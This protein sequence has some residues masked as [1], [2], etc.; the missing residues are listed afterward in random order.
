MNLIE[1]SIDRLKQGQM[2]IIVDDEQRENEGDLVVAAEHITT[3]QMAFMIRHTGGVVCVSLSNAIADKLELPH[4]VHKNT[5]QRTTSFTVS[6]DAAQSITTGISAP[7]RVA[8]I[9]TILNV[10][11]KPN[12]LARPGHVFPLRAEAGGVL[13][14]GGHT[15]ASVDLCRIAGLREAAVISEL[16]N[17]DGT[18]MRGAELLSFAETNQLMI[19]SVADIIAYRHQNETFIELAAKSDLKTETGEWS[20]RVYH[21]TLKNTEHVALV[22]GE[23][24]KDEPVLVR[25]HSECLTG[26]LFGSRHCDC[27]A[28][29]HKAMSLIEKEGRGVL[30]YM[31]QEGRGIGLVNKIKA[32]ELQ[33]Q[34]KMDTIEANA[35]LG[36]PEDLREYGVGAQI[37]KDIGCGKIRLM[38]NNPKKM[39][40]ISG[41]GIEV[42]E[43]VPIEIPPNGVDNDY[44]KTKKTK[45][46]H[47][48]SLV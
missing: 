14:R 4:M 47:L 16:M 8:T 2:I 3:E 41:Y 32:Y 48:L 17:D 18:L 6:V 7:D 23:I 28:Q 45:M 25:V 35:A 20:V 21:D 46:G 11:T 1:Q 26:D 43:Q 10:N 19:I 15:E 9:Q 33:H 36:F 38:T 12:D 31:K 13:W 39:G 24:K 5:S 29:L 40:G 37:L 42:V 30:L 34:K 27:G 22:K 44:L